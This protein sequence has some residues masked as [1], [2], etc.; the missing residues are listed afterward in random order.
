[1]VIFMMQAFF[2]LIVNA[3]ALFVCIFSTEGFFPTDAIGAAVW[4]IG[5]IF[6]V[7]G[8]Y[9]LQKFREDPSPDKGRVI[10]TGLWR[11][12]RHPNYF[13]EAV[14]QWGYYLIA[15]SIDYGWITFFGPL[16]ITFLVRFF[17]GVP[18]L[19]KK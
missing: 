1:M 10:K 9:Q 12:T 13:G 18:M 5:F 8:D 15:C 11:Y 17:S 6:E 16:F 19:E 2:S 14:L 7:V 3:P 4:A